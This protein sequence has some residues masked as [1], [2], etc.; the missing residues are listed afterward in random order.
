MKMAVVAQQLRMS[1]VI[2]AL[3]FAL[4]LT[5]GQP[6]GHAIRSC[7]IGMRLADELDLDDESR[8]SLFYAL[9]LKD[10]GCSSNA[11]RIC[12]LFQ[13]DD[14]RLKQGVKTVDWTKFSDNLIWAMRSVAPEGLAAR[15]RRRARQARPQAGL[16]RRR[17]SRSAV[18]AA[19]RSR[20]SSA[21]PTRR[22][23]AIRSL[24]EHWDGRGQPARARAARRS[25]CSGG[26]CASRRRS[27]S[28][29]RRTGSRRRVPRRARERRGTLVRPRARA[30]RSSAF[31]RDGD[32][33]SRLAAD[34]VAELVR[35][36]RAAGARVSS[37]TTRAL[38]R[39]AG[40][41]ARVID[42]KSPFTARHSERVAEIAVA[43][44]R[45]CSAR[46]RRRCAASAARRCSTTSASSASRT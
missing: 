29:P 46:R 24:D 18:S 28:S 15:P 34:D 42:A 1:E 14:L 13:A 25:R 6:Q 31:E 21:S 23:R 43:H 30:T 11:A 41:F 33:W 8:S 16:G 22:P 10:A 38:D 39:V 44:R 45:A 27:R 2:S 26:S 12:T 17:S 7:V 3:S 9:L 32:F 35:R 4:D 19:P 37:P 5:E 40:A 36:L 20:A